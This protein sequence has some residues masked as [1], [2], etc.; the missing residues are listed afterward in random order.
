LCNTIKPQ[1]FFQTSLVYP[2]MSFY[3]TKFPATTA[4]CCHTSM[5]SFKLE[6]PQSFLVFYNI[7]DNFD[8]SWLAVLY[9]AFNLGCCDVFMIW[10]RM[11]MVGKDTTEVMSFSVHYISSYLMCIAGVLSIVPCLRWYLHMFFNCKVTNF[12]FVID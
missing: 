1:T 10:L 12:P 2:L 6:V 11:Y 3:S 7:L 4:Y 5:L 9:T 8:E